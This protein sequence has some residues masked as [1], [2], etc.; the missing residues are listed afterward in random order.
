MI[1]KNIF[2]DKNSDSEPKYV[3]K[4]IQFIN[5]L[6]E[7]L[8]LER[9][10]SLSDDERIRFYQMMDKD[11]YFLKS[12][13]VVNFSILI[14]IKNST[15]EDQSTFKGVFEK[16]NACLRV[17]ISEFMSES[18]SKKPKHKQAKQE[19]LDEDVKDSLSKI[20]K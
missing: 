15:S 6:D 14:I 3:S 10:F 11:L 12:L 1:L 9:T 8:N 18:C 7:S 19:D 4:Y 5:T 2:S 17:L 20:I 16:S 13:Q